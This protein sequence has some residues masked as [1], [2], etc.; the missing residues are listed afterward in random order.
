MFVCVLVK[1]RVILSLVFDWL[2][3]DEKHISG[4]GETFWVYRNME[5]L[6]T[7]NRGK[8]QSNRGHI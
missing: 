8:A 1:G 2:H 3:H 6:P 4:L 7:L 5:Y